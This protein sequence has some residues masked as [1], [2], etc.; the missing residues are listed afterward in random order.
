VAQTCPHCGATQSLADDPFCGD[1][2]QPLD[3]PPIRATSHPLLKDP[4]RELEE[5][6]RFKKSVGTLAFVVGGLVTLA[7]YV[8]ASQCGGIYVIATGPLIFGVFQF[9]RGVEMDRQAR[10]L[11]AEAAK[12]QTP[13]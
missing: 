2:R 9:F 12:D 1:C 5:G 7:T 13:R 8:L 6:A 4:I 3:E 11:R 10:Q